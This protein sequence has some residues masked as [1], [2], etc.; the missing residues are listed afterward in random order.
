[1]SNKAEA[2]EAMKQNKQKTKVYSYFGKVLDEIV[3]AYGL[4]PVFLEKAI[5]HIEANGK[6]VL[7][8]MFAFFNLAEILCLFKI[9][10]C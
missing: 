10:F 4:C 1:M 6:E 2:W 7:I 9:N 3:P 8:F 5:K